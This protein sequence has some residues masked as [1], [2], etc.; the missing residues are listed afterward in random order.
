MCVVQ[1]AEGVGE[2]RSPREPGCR[3]GMCTHTHT[4]HRKAGC[5]RGG[6]RAGEQH[7]E[8]G[9]CVGSRAADVEQDDDGGGG[10]MRGMG[11]KLEVPS[12]M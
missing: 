12:C 7:H 1:G 8:C 3:A 5:E 10:V 4:E 9:V 11:W 2:P 6:L